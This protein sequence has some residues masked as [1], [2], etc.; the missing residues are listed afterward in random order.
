MFGEKENSFILS[1]IRRILNLRQSSLPAILAISLMFAFLAACGGGG[2][3]GGGGDDEKKTTSI[4]VSIPAPA[5]LGTA[6]FL[7]LANDPADIQAVYIQVDNTVTA[8]TEADQELTFNVGS[9]AYEGTLTSLTVGDLLTFTADAYDTLSAVGFRAGV[10]LFS[11]AD[12]ITLTGAPDEVVTLSMQDTDVVTGTLPTIDGIDPNPGII[13]PTSGT[14]T[15]T[16]DIS[17]AAD[18]T[19]SWTLTQDTPADDGSFDVDLGDLV[20]TGGATSGQVVVVYSAGATEGTFN[21]TLSVTESTGFFT[22]YAPFPITVSAAAVGGMLEAYI[23]PTVASLKIERTE[24][25]DLRFE[26]TVLDDKDPGLVTFNWGYSADGGTLVVSY[27][28]NTA[29]PSF[30]ENYVPEEISGTVTL[31]LIDQDGAASLLSFPLPANQFPDAIGLPQSRQAVALDAGGSIVCA[32]FA[33]GEA[34][35]WGNNTYGRLGNNNTG[36]VN[37]SIP[38]GVRISGGP[39]LTNATQKIST[40][41]YH[42][43]SLVSDG[44]M[45]WGQNSNGQLGDDS[46]TTRAFAANVSSI[47]A[48]LDV[49]V[50][51]EFTC[52]VV[53]DGKVQC[54]GKNQYGKLGT[55]N[56]TLD[57]D[58][59]PSNSGNTARRLMPVNTTIDG[60]AGNSATTIDLASH[61]ACAVMDDSGVKC[62]GQNN[63][64]QLGDDT[65]VNKAGPV[66]VL[67]NDSVSNVPLTGAVAVTLG[68]SHSCAL[69]G[70]GTLRCWGYGN[71]GRLGNGG[72]VNSSLA[73]PVSGITGA[74]AATSATAFNAGDSHTCALMGDGMV[75]CWGSNGNG[76]LGNRNTTSQNTPVDVIGIFPGNPAIA[77]AAGSQITCVTLSGGNMRCW[78]YNAIGQLGDGST[79][80]INRPV[81]VDVP[82]GALP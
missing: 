57:P 69:L 40:W 39:R 15:V 2:G 72:S 26:A 65:L 66:S 63:Y 64:G 23:A 49:A 32:I 8:S 30:L 5:P 52:A 58:T 38:L 28:D 75:K 53:T 17:G 27:P 54:W 13:L 36:V 14:S 3:G 22:V 59:N 19:F 78:G 4:S 1:S 62:W 35:C 82:Y 20:L 31:Q 18:D 7:P 80:N 45:C 44:I 68:T 50:G 71:N 81:G 51:N 42:T 16:I 55:G 77:V 73:V 25:N 33:L 47:A 6:G 29:N 61:H 43:C 10:I 56:F 11:G 48:A 74:D 76:R 21:Y 24:S 34:A 67:Y 70:D 9:G 46:V 12:N 79:I 60:T 41:Y 37:T